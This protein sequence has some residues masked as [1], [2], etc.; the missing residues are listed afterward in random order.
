MV[1]NLNG[2]NFEPWLKFGTFERNMARI[3]NVQMERNGMVQIPNH[4]NTERQNGSDCQM[5]RIL[6]PHCTEY[7]R[8]LIGQK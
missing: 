8:S 7:D 2:S 1:R 3:P 5:V 4:L 6:D